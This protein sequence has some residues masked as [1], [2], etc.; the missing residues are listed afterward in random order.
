MVLVAVGLLVTTGLGRCRGSRCYRWRV[1]LWALALGL[2]GSVAGCKEKL[3]LQGAGQR[4]VAKVSVE[5]DGQAGK[6]DLHQAMDLVKVGPEL[7]NPKMCYVMV[8]ART[9]PKARAELTKGGPEGFTGGK[10]DQASVHK[11]LR[12]RSA[13]FRNCFQ[14]V[15]KKNP[16]AGGEMVLKVTIDANGRATASVDSD[17]TG[18]PRIAE[19][20]IR[21][22]QQWS[23]PKPEGGAATF[24][25]PIVFSAD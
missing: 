20:A 5:R 19:C 17:L 8:Q 2:M 10:V 18:D 15:R 14:Y 4:V 23:F 13:A 16:E 21:K 1:A 22:L 12:P 24:K 11:V 6:A 25:L 7:E 9:P 3:P